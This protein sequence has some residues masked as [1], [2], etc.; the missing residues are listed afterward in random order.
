[1]TKCCP[2]SR[3]EWEMAPWVKAGGCVGSDYYE[4]QVREQKEASSRVRP[5]EVRWEQTANAEAALGAFRIVFK[6]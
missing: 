1:M 5:K 2:G 6:G 4:S 3:V